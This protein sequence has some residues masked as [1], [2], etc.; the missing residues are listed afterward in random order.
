MNGK[1]KLILV[2]I[3]L[4]GLVCIMPVSATGHAQ[5]I[6]FVEKRLNCYPEICVP[7]F[8][9]PPNAAFGSL[10]YQESKFVFNAHGL[11]PETDFTLIEDPWIPPQKQ[12]GTGRSDKNGNIHIK[13]GATSLTY[14]P[15]FIGNFNGQIGAYVWLVPTGELV[16]GAMPWWDWNPIHYVFAQELISPP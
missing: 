9:I 13:G 16:D 7:K 15:K 14:T 12:I 8:I 2:M 1:M 4:A 10:M 3:L 11:P 6:K 5:V